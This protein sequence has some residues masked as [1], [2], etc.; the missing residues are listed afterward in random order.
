MRFHLTPVQ[1]V[2]LYGI[3]LAAVGGL[4]TRYE[5]FWPRRAAAQETGPRP[6]AAAE[7][8]RLDPAKAAEIER[9]AAAELAEEESS[10][11]KTDA[12]VKAKP[13]PPAEEIN[14]LEL[15]LA[16]GPLMWPIFAVS[17]IAFAF[18][19]ERTLGLRRHKVIPP[20]LIAGL[21]AASS[22]KG[23]LDLRQ[24]YKLCQQFPSTAASVIKAML[25]KAGRPH[26]EV[27][28]AAAEASEREASRL[29]SN[30]RWIN[31]AVA[32]APML[33]LLGT[34]QGMIMA[35]FVTAHLPVGANKTESLAQGIYIALVTTF[36]GLTVAIPAAICS[37]LFEGRIQR[38]FRELDEVLMGLLP[39]LE[40]Y[41]GRLRVSQEQLEV[42]PTRPPVADETKR[43]PA[44]SL[45]Q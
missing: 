20:E 23:G 34:I 29:Y 10:D 32:V 42:D 3:T 27:E 5:A 22:P 35:F 7:N 21:G 2:A 30:V 43:K 36:A 25:L 28:H 26:T 45:P 19:V 1:R 17:I 39:Q 24:A 15:T 18:A 37:H 33:G 13:A 8:G 12:T 31:L 4:M 41:E 6:P 44:A 9:K 11:D 16:G 14:I 38:L 40:R